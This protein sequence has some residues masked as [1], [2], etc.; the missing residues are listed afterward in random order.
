MTRHA[1]LS[2]AVR[3]V[4]KERQRQMDVEGWTLA[5]D[6]GHDRRE[7]ARAAAVYAICDEHDDELATRSYLSI[8][9]LGRIWPWASHWFKPRDHRRNLV[10]AAA[11]L[12][13]E[14]ERLDRRSDKGEG[15]E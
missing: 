4:V 8:S 14:I 5:H 15:A 3:D 9:L 6:D 11:L 7:L 10:R 1:V 12:I 2:I 13:A